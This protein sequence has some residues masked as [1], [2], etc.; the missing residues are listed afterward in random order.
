MFGKVQPRRF[1]LDSNVYDQLVA[2]PERQIEVI[3]SCQS[4]EI[5]LLMTHVQLDELTAMADDAKR[6]RTLAIP[7]TPV[8][9]YGM[10]LGTSR[11]GLARFGESELIDSV[12]SEE[13]NHTN[14][15][16][17]AATAKYEQAILVT[18]DIRL[19]RRAIEIEV[20]VWEPTKFLE[21]LGAPS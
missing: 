3:G 12:R 16:L 11:V 7:F 2:S 8:P 21:L 18:N 17:L 20:K 1:L 9:T 5:E 6:R 10:V 13:G 19:S 4:G 15:A 14:D